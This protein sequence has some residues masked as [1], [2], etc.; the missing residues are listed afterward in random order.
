MKVHGNERKNTE[1][2][3][4]ALWLWRTVKDVSFFDN[5]PDGSVDVCKE[6]FLLSAC[7]YAACLFLLPGLLPKY[8]KAGTG[9][10]EFFE[11]QVP[12]RDPVEQM[13]DAA[14]AEEDLPFL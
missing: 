9:E 7:P 2:Y 1:V 6:T 4:G 3:G 11:F 8:R 13:E 14:G 5:Y 12:K 10:S